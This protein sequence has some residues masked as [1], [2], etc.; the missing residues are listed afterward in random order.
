MLLTTVLTTALWLG[1]T[2]LTKPESEQTL[3]HFYDLVRPAPLGW[4]RFATPEQRAKPE[5]RWNFLHWILG[6]SLIYLMLFGVGNV[7]FSRTPL[8]LLMIG[9][10]L[11]CLTVLLL[12]LNRQG[13]GSFKA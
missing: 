1:V 5:L 9:G 8:G 4:S 13:W 11:A 12:S 7:L 6:F 3:R 10:A 2:L